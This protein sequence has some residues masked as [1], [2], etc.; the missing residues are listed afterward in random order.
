[1]KLEQE[2]RLPG[3]SSAMLE[4]ARRVTSAV[5]SEIDLVRTL[6]PLASPA[7]TG[8][9]TAPNPAAGTR[10]TRIATMQMFADEFT[11]LKSSIGWQKFP[12]G[13]ILQQGSY[14]SLT[15]GDVGVSFPVAFPS[16][17][18]SVVTSYAGGG[19]AGPYIATV[20]AYAVT[21]FNASLFNVAGTR[22]AGSCNWFAVGF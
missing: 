17:V 5:N 14:V 8:A 19:A 11:A 6:A 4:W 1:M 9:P 18:C 10:G 3:Q 22:V 2:P 15:S 12:S 7:L 13:Y 20:G 16:A 21:G